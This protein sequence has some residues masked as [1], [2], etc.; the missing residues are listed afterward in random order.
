[1][2][3][4]S[5]ASFQYIRFRCSLILCPTLFSELLQSRWLYLSL[6]LHLDS[7]SICH[8]WPRRLPLSLTISHL[9]KEK[10]AE[11]QAAEKTTLLTNA[12]T[13]CPPP[14][15]RPSSA[16]SSPPL[17]SSSP[18]PAPSQR[19]PIP[20]P[21]SPIPTP[22]ASTTPSPHSPSVHPRLQLLASIKNHKSRLSKAHLQ[23]L[24]W[25]HSQT[26]RSQNGQTRRRRPIPRRHARPHH[27]PQ[28]P[29]SPASA[30]AAITT[31]RK[32]PSAA[33][34]QITEPLP[35]PRQN[36]IMRWRRVWA[37]LCW[38]R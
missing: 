37:W 20:L 31:M 15:P 8:F 32:G 21:Y 17:S 28:P 4:I 3:R 30:Q 1:M 16:S 25:L 2:K 9:L 33:P 22:S 6:P 26:A 14:S 13:Q 35:T 7:S 18:A 36:G 10:F 27:P 23:K 19:Q 11:L 5:F 29:K 38:R 12:T 34:P 24:Q